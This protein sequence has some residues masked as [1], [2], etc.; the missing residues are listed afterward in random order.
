MVRNILEMWPAILFGWPAI[1]AALGLAVTGIMRSK[2]GWPLVG[3]ILV[4]PIS[5]YLAG[6]PRFGWLGISIPLLLSGASIA[7][8]YQHSRVAWFLLTPFVGTFAWLA[9]MLMNE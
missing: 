6:S 7:I 8:Y 3:A 9:V 1:L 4:L 2:P 5:L